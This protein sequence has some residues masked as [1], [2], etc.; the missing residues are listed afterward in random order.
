MFVIHVTIPL[1]THRGVTCLSRESNGVS[2]RPT[3]DVTTVKCLS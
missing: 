2:K 3:D 1:G